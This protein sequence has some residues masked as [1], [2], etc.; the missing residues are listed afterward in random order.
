MGLGKVECE[1]LLVS[2]FDFPGNSWLEKG[3]ESSRKQADWIKVEIERN[4]QNFAEYRRLRME[5][6]ATG[7]E[8]DPNDAP[9]AMDPHD[10]WSLL[11]DE[12]CGYWD[13]PQPEKG[14]PGSSVGY[15]QK[16]RFGERF[17]NDL[18]GMIGESP[19]LQ[20]VH[21]FSITD[22]VFLEQQVAALPAGPSPRAELGTPPVALLL[23]SRLLFPSPC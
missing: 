13:P 11:I 22:F 16:G 23:L 15:K 4:N 21:G 8:L 18:Q 12:Y 6:A 5:A 20:F 19:F 7:K 1:V 14:R 9:P 3:W 10:F 17:R 2:A